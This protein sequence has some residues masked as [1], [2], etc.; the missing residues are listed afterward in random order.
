MFNWFSAVRLCR[1]HARQ[2]LPAQRGERLL[3]GKIAKDAL[4]LRGGLVGPALRAVTFAQPEPRRGRELP[5][6]VELRRERLVIGDGRV[7]VAIG[8][9]LEQALLQ[10]CGE[11]VGL[12]AQHRRSQKKNSDAQFCFHNLNDAS[13]PKFV[14]PIVTLLQ[15]RKRGGIFYK[16]TKKP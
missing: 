15:N 5:V 14:R 4:V 9:L 11:V 2:I 13:L 10:E 1:V 8:L 6:L 12:R 16:E 3:V 7:E